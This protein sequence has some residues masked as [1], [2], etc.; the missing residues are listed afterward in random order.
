MVSVIICTYN[1]E[2][3]IRQCMESVVNQTIGFGDMEIIIVDDASTDATVEILKEYKKLYP[4]HIRL[5]LRERNSLKTMEVNR[6]IAV[7]CAS[8][9]YILFLDQDDWYE[10]DAA[11]VLV[12]LMEEETH[13]DYIEYGVQYVDTAGKQ[14]KLKGGESGNFFVFEIENEQVRKDLVKQGVLPG[15]TPVW[16]K[17]YRRKF[18]E[19]NQIWHNDGNQRSGFSD[20]YFSGM[21]VM[22][23]S[24]IGKLERPM[25]HYRNYMGS[26]SHSVT[27]DSNR[28]FERCKAGIAFWAE[29]EK[30]GLMDSKREMAEYV[31]VRIFLLK[32]FWKFLLNYEQIPFE[33]LQFCQREMRS[34]GLDIGENQI[35]RE[36]PEMI[37]LATVTRAEW[38]PEFLI[39]L[40][41]HMMEQLREKKISRSLLFL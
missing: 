9:D 25:I 16:N 11:E 22:Y 19:E 3:Y 30:R 2:K 5:I 34:R 20:N 8:G 7:C 14:L 32:T 40:R 31:F 1:G 17:I 15:L 36:R 21:L 38:T 41:K 6:N 10:P 37:L 39:F 18:L 26:W 33:M 27:P 29:C 23:C 12:G 4:E 28:Q 13:L 35:M 24:K